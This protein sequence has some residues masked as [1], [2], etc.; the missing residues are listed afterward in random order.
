MKIKI[1]LS[2]QGY[3][4]KP[5][6]NAGIIKTQSSY[7]LVE[8]TPEEL[9]NHLINGHY[10]HHE[11]GASKANTGKDGLTFKK[12]LLKQAQVMQIDFD[13]KLKFT[14]IVKGEETI[15]EKH[16]EENEMPDWNKDLL[17]NL[18]LTDKNGNEFNISPSFWLES[19]SAHTETEKKIVG[20]SIHLF[21]VF[22]DPIYNVDDYEKV[23][24]SI[25][26]CIWLALQNKGYNIPL[27]KSRSPFDPVSKDM[28]QGMWGS[29]GKNSYYNGNTYFWD[30]LKDAYNPKMKEIMFPIEQY[31]TAEL[32]K[33]EINRTINAY[34]TVES[35]DDIDISKSQYIKYKKY[36]GHEE[37]WHIISVLKCEYAKIETDINSK[38]SLCYQV[39]KKLLLGHS[40]D[41]TN[42]DEQRFYYEYKR[43]KAYSINGKT[44]HLNHVI[45]LIGDTGAIPL[46]EY[47][48]TEQINNNLI[49]LSKTEYLS[50]K[51][52]QIL[53]LLDSNKINRIIAAPGLGKTVWAKSLKGRTLIIE[54]YNSIITSEEKFSSSDFN[55]FIESTYINP[56][57]DQCHYDLSITNCSVSSA[58][59]FVTWYMNVIKD[60]RYNQFNYYGMTE[61]VLFNNIILDESHLLCLSNYRYDIMGDTIKYLKQ[62]KI[63]YP[64]TNIIIMTGTP[65][66]EDVIF[67]DL[68]TIEIKSEPRYNRKF[69]MVQTSS[70]PGYMIELIKEKLQNGRRIFIPVDSENWFDSFIDKCVEEGVISKDK[71]YYF[72]QPKKREDTELM[73]LNTKLIGDIKILG[74][75]SYMSVGIDLEDWKTEF[76]TIVPSG[77]AVSGNF[78]GIEVE[79][80]ANRHRKQNLECYYV[81]SNNESNNKKP[82]LGTSCRA[83]LNIKNDLLKAMYRRD[84]IVIHIPNYLEENNSL[85]E[86]NEDRYNVF[87][88]YKDMKPIISHPMVIYEYMQSI[89]WECIWENVDHPERGI[90]EK[91]HREEI[92][93]AGV[94]EFITV[95]NAWAE[96]N[97]P[98][99][100]IRESIGEEL[101]IIRNKLSDAL[102]DLESI[103]VEFTNYYAK[104]VLFNM[105]L[106]IREYLTG[107][108]TYK[109]I[110]DAYDGEK[111]NMAFI[112]RTLYA[113]KLVNNYSATGVW[114]EI[115]NKLA[116][117]YNQYSSYDNCVYKDNKKEF[118]K[119]LNNVIQG[120]WDNLTSK[121]DDDILKKV[122]MSNYNNITEDLITDFMS[123]IKLICTMY[124]N[125]ETICK[126]IGKK[127][128]KVTRYSWNSNNLSR[129]NIRTDKQFN[130]F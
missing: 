117:F 35:I 19:F 23:S 28:F 9:Y 93:E 15:I 72:N 40:N 43:Q 113:I 34:S 120:I 86:V 98:I 71:C 51:N 70:I 46:I 89:G 58:N 47:K 17:S 61:G 24:I 104:N 67:N 1:Y 5:D 83:L 118:E 22:E 126:K 49:K 37:T 76:T 64:E 32:T 63:D 42:N 20:N 94:H 21:Y 33:D 110:M 78:S 123:G 77:V 87:C 14:K 8:I 99:I 121:V 92:K 79:Q 16:Y 3:D 45:R 129:Y 66:G 38:Q 73:I 82:F 114:K 84:P 48:Q 54:L 65:F 55:K 122:L 69:H 12:A 81:I 11:C 102:F 91:E 124:L 108:G 2:K 103:E 130:T 50:D 25:M 10:V 74:T 101:V 29:Y 53:N 57:D 27:E 88:Y 109:L 105:L 52:D 119:K 96:G 36:F 90:N 125:K 80:F 44:I 106:S 100:K 7:N 115:S 62:L 112:N 107:E 75:S 56:N 111:I 59:K 127:N 60:H 30:E 18:T 13:Y 26:Y 68:N 97:Y 39:C 41:F 128:C 4:K 6:L 85:L 116:N 31:E 95:L